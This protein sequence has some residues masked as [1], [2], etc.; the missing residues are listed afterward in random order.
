MTEV[1]AENLEA[2]E[3]W[4]GVLFD[5]FLLYRDLVVPALADLGKRGIRICPP[6]PGDRVLDVGCGFG[7]STQD[8]ARL[9]GPSGSALGVDIAPRFIERAQAEAEEAGV[10]N[11][12]FEVRDV[13]ATEFDDTFDYVYSRFGTMFFDNPV[14]AFRNVHRAMAP[15]GRLCLVVWRRRED[16][17]W[18]YVAENVV[19]PWLEEPEETDEP[20]CGPGPFSQANADT[21]SGQV[22]SAGFDEIMLH[23]FDQPF[24]FGHSLEQAVEMNLALGPAAEALRLAGDEGESVRPRLEELLRGA[25]A[26]FIRDDG[27]VEAM[28]S[29]WIVTA[30]A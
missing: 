4:D 29:I 12:R 11:V 24:V 19:K 5:R 6:E 17:P 22:R 1:A 25:L 21:V 13:Q 26:Q 9:A 14:P 15:G 30:R 3:A 20:R 2:Q 8:L 27:R 28:S 23:R 18:L 16:N 10:E 7:D